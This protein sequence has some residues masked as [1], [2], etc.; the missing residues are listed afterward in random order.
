M[1]VS[2]RALLSS[3]GIV[4]ANLATLAVVWGTGRNVHGLLVVYWLETGIVSAVYVAKIRRAEGTDDPEHVRSW[5]RFDG[6]P[7]DRLVG[8]SNRTIAD[9]VVTNFAGPWVVFG[10]FV[11]LAAPL[12][13]VGELEPASPVAVV[14]ATVG[15]LVYHVG[16]YRFE[17]VGFRE[18]ERRGPVSLFV[19]LAPRHLA[20]VLTWIFGLGAA[21]IARSPVGALVVLV[22]LKT[23]VDLVAHRRERSLAS[24]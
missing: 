13:L 5:A 9:A 8:E 20:V 14:L 15:L 18:Y 4:L 12:D 7:A 19:E 17:Y 1:S 3:V 21:S 16:S 24:A 6:K 22:G 2:T 11:V 10:A 23:C